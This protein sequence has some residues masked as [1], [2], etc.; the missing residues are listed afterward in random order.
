MYERFFEVAFGRNRIKKQ[1]GFT[2]TNVQSWRQ[3]R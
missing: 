3:Q 2:D 1:V